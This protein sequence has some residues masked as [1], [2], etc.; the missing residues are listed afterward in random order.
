M[1]LS[2]LIQGDPWTTD[3]PAAA[4][5]FARA[6]VAAGHGVRRA[7]F[8]GD[9]ASI[10]NRGAMPPQDEENIAAAWVEFATCHDIPLTACIASAARR[11]VVDADAAERLGLAGATVRDGFELGGL[12]QMIEAMEGAERTVTFGA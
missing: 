6:A 11:G 5:K 12:G 2:L 7:F 3:A 4:L 10:A 1:Q 9:A 8:H